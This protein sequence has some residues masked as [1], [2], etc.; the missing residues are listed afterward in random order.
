MDGEEELHILG[1]S[2]NAIKCI[3][4]SIWDVSFANALLCFSAQ[5]FLAD[6]RYSERGPGIKIQ[7]KQSSRPECSK[8]GWIRYISSSSSTFIR[9]MMTMLYKL[10]WLL[11]MNENAF[12]H[13]LG[14]TFGWTRNKHLLKWVKWKGELQHQ[15]IIIIFIRTLIS[16]LIIIWSSFLSRTSSVLFL[17][18]S[19]F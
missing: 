10:A 2:N 16:M 9:L 11:K 5:T 15:I 19:W 4:M 8:Q 7:N 1:F 6:I 12:V 13:S 18:F 3:A 14:K 17:V